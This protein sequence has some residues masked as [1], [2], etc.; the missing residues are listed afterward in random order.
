MVANYTSCHFY[1]KKPTDENNIW[2]HLFHTSTVSQ[3]TPLENHMYVKKWSPTKDLTRNIMA[4]NFCFWFPPMWSAS[5]SS[6]CCISVSVTLV[7]VP[8]AAIYWSNCPPL[9][10]KGSSSVDL[11]NWTLNKTGVSEWAFLLGKRKSM[12]SHS[13]S[14]SSN[15]NCRWNKQLWMHAMWI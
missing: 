14:S 5:W 1:K 10:L 4:F 13:F 3:V 7:V 8:H 2:T 15:T 12:S 6:T 9:F 11:Q